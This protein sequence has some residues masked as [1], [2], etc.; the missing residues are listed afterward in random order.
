MIS[1]MTGGY[2]LLGPAM[3]A[4][5]TAFILSGKRCIFPAQVDSRLDSPF[6]ADEFEPIVLR[7][8]KATMS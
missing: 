5:V 7:R 2:G 6:H 8:F 3:L 4:V 1:E